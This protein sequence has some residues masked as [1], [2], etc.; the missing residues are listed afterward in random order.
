MVWLDGLDGFGERGVGDEC[1]RG[2]DVADGVRTMLGEGSVPGELLVLAQPLMATSN[3]VAGI[4][5]RRP[6]TSAM[7]A[8]G[9]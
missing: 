3:A 2:D 6:F 1:D 7:L 4:Q 9:T 5:R 8:R